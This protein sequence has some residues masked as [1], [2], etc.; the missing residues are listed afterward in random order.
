MEQNMQS[1]DALRQ[2]IDEVDRQLV[3]LFKER[4]EISAGVAKYKRANGKQVYDAG[5]PIG[6]L[7]RQNGLLIDLAKEL[8]IPV[9]GKEDALWN[10]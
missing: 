10:L 7:N 3:D 6:S 2:R 5:A 1:L 9:Y 8:G 4:M